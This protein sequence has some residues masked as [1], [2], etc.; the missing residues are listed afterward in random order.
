MNGIN[1]ELAKKI[2]SLEENQREALLI[3]LSSLN[4]AKTRSERKEVEIEFRSLIENIVS[5]QE[6]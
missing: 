6:R 4:N 2:N 1:L 5:E 3:L